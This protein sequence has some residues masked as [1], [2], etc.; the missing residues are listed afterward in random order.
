MSVIG[1]I[2]GDIAGSLYEFKPEVNVRNHPMF[3]DKHRATDDSYMSIATKI[4][5][6]E[7]PE[8]PDFAKWYHYI[9]NKYCK[10]FCQWQRGGYPFAQ[11]CAG[12]EDRHDPS[13]F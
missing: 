1:A 13:A 5:V 3:T 10:I 7:N 6:L 8:K 12:S 11:G 9:G 2:L 4:A